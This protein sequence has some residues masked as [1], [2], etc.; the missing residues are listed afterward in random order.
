M[1]DATVTTETA[2]AGDHAS[3]VAREAAHFGGM[4]A[5]W[6]DPHGSS[7]MLHRLNP[8][9]LRYIREQAD[10]HFDL[11]PASF[12]PLAGKT[13][14]DVGCGAGLLAEPL[15]RLGAAIT[16]IDAAPEN[17][18][19]ARAH[20]ATSGLAIDYRTGGV[21]A[22]AGE[23]FDLVTCLEVIEHVADPAAFV[24]GLAGALADGGLLIMSTPNR[25][26]MSRV[27]MI[28]LAEGTGRIPRGTHDWNRFVTPD[29]LGN[30]LADAG[31]SVRDTR[32]IAF[33]PTS[34]FSLSDSL[35][36]NYLI[37]ATRS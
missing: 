10:R 19:I 25:T 7:A 5:E 13:A 31:L 34:G 12:T 4:A 23:R 24:A 26:P 16:A 17:I 2:P 18:A 11:D 3:I 29:E 30:M 15:K 8:V 33:S 27:A 28:T 36:L 37:T 22:V 35:A 6:W 32:G 21:E 9:R 14:L 1:V 20:A